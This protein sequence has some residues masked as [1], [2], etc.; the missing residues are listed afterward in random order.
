[1]E[2]VPFGFARQPG[3]NGDEKLYFREVWEDK[4]IV[5]HVGGQLEQNQ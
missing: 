1:M 2:V 5:D 3:G 4:T